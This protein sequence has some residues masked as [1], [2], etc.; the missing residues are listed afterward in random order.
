LKKNPNILIISDLFPQ[1]EKDY[2]GIYVVDYA[3]SVQPWFDV[4]VF[5]PKLMGTN[6]GTRNLTIFDL[7]VTRYAFTNKS[8]GKI[9]KLVAYNSWF[10][11][12]TE[13]GNS[14]GKFDLIHAHGSAL[15]GNVA[16]RIAK[17]QGI[18]YL[19]TEH[20]GPFSAI[21][22]NP[23]RLKYCKS[24]IKDAA[25][26]LNVSFHSQNEMNQA[27]VVHEKQEVT[28]NPVNVQVFQNKNQQRAKQLLFVSRFDEFKGGLRTL[29]AFQESKLSEQGW[30][31]IFIGEGEEEEAMKQYANE[32]QM[33]E[34]EFQGLQT[35]VEINKALNQSAAL[36]FPSRHETFGLVA[37]ESLT[38]GTPV[39]CTNQTGPSEYTNPSNSISVQ[40]DQIEDIKE[41]MLKIANADNQFDHQLIS[42]NAIKAFGLD[43]F[44]LKLKNI[45]LQHIR[46]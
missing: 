7:L 29:K 43:A 21:S 6:K 25:A 36:V 12:A 30:K 23:T 16:K 3:K 1:D 13:I 17:Q 2:A 11:Q 20:T 35:K 14:I 39:I 28:F 9:K 42:E 4:H 15:A 22:N 31:L 46:N 8:L 26:L 19:I 45:Y 44:G 33:G 37:A 24:A 38:C 18:N 34:V 40:P 41:A 27:G 5:H 32:H 10:K